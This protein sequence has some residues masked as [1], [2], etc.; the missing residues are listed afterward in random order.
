MKGRNKLFDQSLKEM[1]K[2]I[3]GLIPDMLS[4]SCDVGLKNNTGDCV[5]LNFIE[6]L[7]K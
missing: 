4:V 1:K 7:V 2:H 3:P 6:H 5:L